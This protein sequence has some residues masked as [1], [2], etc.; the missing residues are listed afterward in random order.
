M[1]GDVEIE[2]GSGEKRIFT[3]G[4]ILLAED[5]NGRGHISRSVNNK[6]RK[7][8]FITLDD[9]VFKPVEIIWEETKI[10]R[11]KLIIKDIYMQTKSDWSRNI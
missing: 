10:N 11:S 7:S 2:V 3:S 4:D 5:T 6:P 8:I 1:L 9:D